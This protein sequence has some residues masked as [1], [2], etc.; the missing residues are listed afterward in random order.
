MRNESINQLKHKMHRLEG[1]ATHAS[2]FLKTAKIEK[3]CA[4]L[5]FAK[6]YIV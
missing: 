5:S 2:V 6:L 1:N 3:N 4:S